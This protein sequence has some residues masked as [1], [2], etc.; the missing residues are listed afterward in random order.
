MDATGELFDCGYTPAQLERLAAR[1]FEGAEDLPQEECF[2]LALC[3][4]LID[5]DVHWLSDTGT[6]ML[7]TPRA[8]L[9]RR[10]AAIEV[11]KAAGDDLPTAI[12]AVVG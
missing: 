9:D 2:M 11:R 6:E 7:E 4:G 5:G 8:E 1:M 12:R 10:L 3:V